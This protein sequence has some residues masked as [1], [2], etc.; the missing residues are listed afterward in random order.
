[1][2]IMLELYDYVK[3]SAHSFMSYKTRKQ[4]KKFLKLFGFKFVS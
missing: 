4:V 1:M 2:G 3:T